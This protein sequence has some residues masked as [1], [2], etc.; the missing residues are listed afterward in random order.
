MGEIE[1]STGN[2]RLIF[3][4]TSYPMEPRPKSSGHSA[5]TVESKRTPGDPQLFITSVG[6][7]GLPQKQMV[8]T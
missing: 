5:T 7:K 4:M 3:E 1:K 2:K 8:S 6:E